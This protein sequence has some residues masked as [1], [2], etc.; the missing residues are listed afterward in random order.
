MRLSFLWSTAFRGHLLKMWQLALIKMWHFLK[1]ISPFF[2]IILHFCLGNPIVSGQVCH[3]AYLPSWRLW[4]KVNMDPWVTKIAILQNNFFVSS[5]TDYGTNLP[6]PCRGTVNPLNSNIDRAL[7]FCALVWNL[8]GPFSLL[9][10]NFF[11]LWYCFYTP[12]SLVFC[13]AYICFVIKYCNKFCWSV[14]HVKL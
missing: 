7:L 5:L 4:E 12:F 6:L 13:H 2:Y 11:Y 9:Y 10:L 3:Q 1:G 14:P 8:N